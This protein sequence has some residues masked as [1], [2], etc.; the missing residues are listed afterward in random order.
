[1]QIARMG[2]D[3]V[4][5]ARNGEKGARAL[6]DVRARAGSN[7]VSLLLCDFSS[8]ASIRALA[9]AFRSAH[10]RLDVLVNN[11]GTVSPER[12]VTADG[13]E[14][15]FA[16]NHLGS[17][18]L[19][20]QLLDLLVHSAPAR[21]V[22]VASGAHRSGRID[23]SNLQFEHGGYSLVAAYSRSKLANILFTD[24]LARRLA[25]KGVTANSLHPGVVATDI[26][27]R[28]SWY[29]KPFVL[30]IKPFMISAERGGET[31]VH[32]ATSLEVEGK[33]GGYYVKNRR[34]EPA[35]GATDRAAA[36][37]LWTESA[38]LLKLS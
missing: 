34:V 25:G 33:S 29:F 27:N 21:I 37:R 12:V 26:W 38:R 10:Q 15:T 23:F 6:A 2:A 9:A 22:N 11:A 5:V 7:R 4:I 28:V 17:F 8:L 30:L 18:L 16:V 13:F 3:L 32:L 31:I 1:M 35:S 14:L 19:T 20:N 36:E 24:E